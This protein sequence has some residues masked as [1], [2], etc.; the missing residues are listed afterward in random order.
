MTAVHAARYTAALDGTEWH[1]PIP[2]R[3]QATR[4][5]RKATR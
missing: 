3:R 2:T 5:P 4:R 1:Q